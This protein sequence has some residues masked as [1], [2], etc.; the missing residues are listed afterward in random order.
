M[1]TRYWSMSV[2][3][4][5]LAVAGTAWAALDCGPV[6]S[7]EELGFTNTADQCSGDGSMV[8]CPFDETAVFCRKKATG[9]GCEVG[10]VL[11]SDLNCYDP[12]AAPSGL[13]AIGVVFDTD[14]KLAIGL[15]TETK[16][17]WGGKGTDIPDLRNCVQEKIWLSSNSYTFRHTCFTDSGKDNTQKIV[18]ALGDTSD[19]A[20][21]YC[22]NLVEGG[23]P[24]G[25]W[26]LP[27]FK[28][29][30]YLVGKT[31]TVNTTINKVGGLKVPQAAVVSDEIDD[32]WGLMVILIENGGASFFKNSISNVRCIVGY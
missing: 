24:K 26:F 28:E 5:G 31:S 7:C 18:A 2:V 23:L 10:S 29:L 32:E 12:D 22:Y 16:L 4:G 11:Y 17:V 19:Y 25:S 1:R 14:K 3:L 20:A 13:T 21:G 6:P 8:K 15:N 9:I 30:K 27:S